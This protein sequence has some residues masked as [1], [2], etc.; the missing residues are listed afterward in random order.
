MTLSLTQEERQAVMLLMGADRSYD[1]DSLKKA[2]RGKVK[3]SHPDLAMSLGKDPVLMKLQF[4][5]LNDAFHLLLEKIRQD[6]NDY[7]K[8]VYRKSRPGAYKPTSQNTRKQHARSEYTRNRYSGAEHAEKKRSGNYQKKKDPRTKKTHSQYTNYSSRPKARA[9]SSAEG[10]KYYKGPMPGRILRFA[11]YLY[12]AGEISW[13]D[14]VHALVWQYRNRPKLGE[15]AEETG[16]LDQNDILFII[17]NRHFTEMF[18][19]AA[20]RLGKLDRK[21][22]DKLVRQQKLMGLPIGRFF[23]ENKIFSE[24]QLCRKLTRYRRHNFYQGN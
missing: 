15:L 8:H 2:Y 12:Y 6:N 19:E 10:P 5:E 7:T 22:V 3:T 18:G 23:L 11:E 9:A 14:L 20:I 1:E 4:Q 13:E 21:S 24:E 17:K 16:A